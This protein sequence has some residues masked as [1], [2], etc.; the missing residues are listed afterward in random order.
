MIGA[1]AKFLQWN[2]A[3]NVRKNWK[4]TFVN[5][6]DYGFFL[7]IERFVEPSYPDL[8]SVDVKFTVWNIIKSSA[9]FYSSGTRINIQKKKR[10][11]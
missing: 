6:L 9:F 1:S 4:S 2:I 11:K 10:K 8:A 3:K 7:F 5:E